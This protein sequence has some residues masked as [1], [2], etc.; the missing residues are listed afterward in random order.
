M[1]FGRIVNVLGRLLLVEAGLMIPPLLV[2]SYYFGPDR[3][4]F[5]LSILITGVAGFLFSYFFKGRKSLGA[6]EGLTIVALGWI[7]VSLFGTLPFLLSGSIP[8]FIDAF[9]ETVSGFTTTGATILVNVELLPRGLLF[10][11]SFTH[12]IGG[13][14]ILVFTIALIPKLSG[15]SFQ[16]FKVE[17][18]GP[19]PD[20]IVPKVSD[21]AKVLYT[22]Y[23]AITISQIFF[24]LL[25]DMPLFDSVLHTFGTVGT[26]GFG[27]KNES[28]GAYD[29][30]YLHLVIATFMI[31]A[32][33]N[34][35]LYYSLFKGKWQELF[36]DQELCLY[37]TVILGAIL[38][39][40]FNINQTLYQDIAHSLRDAFFQVASIITT[41]GYST[42][43]FNQWPEFSQMIIFA[44][45]FMGGSAGST[46]GGMKVVRILVV[47][48]QIKRE[49]A[50]IFHPRAV[51]PIKIGNKVLSDERV[52][53]I[54]SFMGIYMLVFI[55]GS[56]L[57]SLEGFGFETSITATISALSNI[58]PGLALVGPA[59][60]FNIF[61][62]PGKLLI[63]FLMLLGRLEFFTM[64]ALLA[65]STWKKE[66]F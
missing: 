55:I 35:S 20:R 29:S 64:I 39:I 31:F 14:G 61:S 45:M 6:K 30:S 27:I 33:I 54:F 37:F 2:S 7:L 56:I 47:F 66:L 3:Q 46:A 43:D 4:A 48:K 1:D 36:K 11:R 8:F 50:K 21:T 44:L 28:I 26:G 32:G 15:G 17:S 41:T 13:M 49:I 42:V 62:G 9:F 10:W 59:E 24:L 12:W 63:S 52:S 58:G 51:I 38:L 22:T 53:G 5:L 34:F 65:P 40:T 23:F 57:L 18:P 19:A 60:N 16:I 25:G